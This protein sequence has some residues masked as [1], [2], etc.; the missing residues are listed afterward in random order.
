MNEEVNLYLEIAKDQMQESIVHLENVLSKIRA[1]KTNPQ[2]L[3]SVVLDYYGVLTPLAQ[4]ANISTPDAQTISVQPFDKNLISD[5]DRLILPGVGHFGFAMKK[6][7]FFKESI[8]EFLNKKKP[9]MGI[10]LGMQL[11]YE[12][13]EEDN[14]SNYGLNIFKGKVIKFPSDNLIIPHIQMLNH[15]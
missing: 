8:L 2:M 7:E 13:S 5:A 11:L 1:G 15:H 9:F 10:C 14:F 4:T 3:R 6:L 12:K